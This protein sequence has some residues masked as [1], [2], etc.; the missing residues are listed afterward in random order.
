MDRQNA[1]TLGVIVCTSSK[2]K[3]LPF[4]EA[5]FFQQLAQ[6]ARPYR[7]EIF[8]FNPKE[9]DWNSR[10]VKGWYYSPNQ[11][12]VQ[13]VRPI[14]SLIYDRCY[15]LNR[16]HYLSYKPFVKKLAEDPK[17]RLLGRALGGKYQTYILLKQS[18][19][20]ARYLPE[21]HLYH[22]SEQ[23][24]KILKRLKT[25]CIKPNGGSHGIGV[26]KISTGKEGFYVKGRN[27][28][29]QPFQMRFS[30]ESQLKNWIKEFIGPTRYIIQPFLQLTTPDHQ[31]FDLRILVQKNGKKEWQTTGMAIRLGK[32][33]S[34]TS[35]LHGGG[36][37]LKAKPF[38]EAIYSPQIVETIFE[39]IEWLSANVPP[40]L[41]DRHGHLVELGLDVG[42]D[43]QGKV[44]ILEL[45]SKPGRTVFIHTG[46]LNIRRRAIHTPI[47]L[48]YTLFTGR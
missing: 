18:Q 41:E 14:P 9:I 15:Y 48:A 19:E 43:R 1:Y 35:N 23:V 29:N 33:E 28:S 36:N 12:W 39:Q 26:V 22:S 42:I 13:Q 17:I 6:E 37:A 20:I 24:L 31:P 21:T 40:Y 2:A 3:T 10:T 11:K 7:I 44:W 4:S 27:K 47:E 16:F 46:E 45:N 38:L 25:I 34:I 5:L 8:V 30:N 32:A